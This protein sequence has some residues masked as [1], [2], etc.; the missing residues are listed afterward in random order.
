MRLSR[1]TPGALALAL[2]RHTASCRASEPM[3][4]RTRDGLR[5]GGWRYLLPLACMVPVGAGALLHGGYARGYS[6][7]RATTRLLIS[8]GPIGLMTWFASMAEACCASPRRPRDILDSFSKKARWKDE[9]LV[10]SRRKRVEDGCCD[11][12]GKRDPGALLYP[13]EEATM[14]LA[15]RTVASGLRHLRPAPTFDWLA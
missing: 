15:T 14:A 12:G 3:L 8:I 5:E 7:V 10:E 2:A 1:S 4:S 11:D 6:V 9:L 13:E